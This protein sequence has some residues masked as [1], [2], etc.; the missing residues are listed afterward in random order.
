M[1][2]STIIYIIIAMAIVIIIFYYF[3]YIKSD[4]DNKKDIPY[5]LLYGREKTIVDLMKDISEK[6]GKYPAHKKKIK[7]K[8]KTISYS[9]YY[10]I[11]NIFAEKLL[12][13]VGP[14]PRVAILSFNRPEWVSAHMGTM[15]SG[16]VS[17]GIYPTASASNCTYITNHSHVD[18][19]VIEDAKQLAKFID[20][21][22]PTVKYIL[23]LDP[24]SIFDNE[25]IEKETQDNVIETIKKLNPNI[26]I[27]KYDTFMNQPLES[28]S[29]RTVIDMRK[30][31]LEDIATIIYTSGTTGDPKGVVLTHKNIIS[32]IKAV[33]NAI[34]SRSNINI[35]VQESYIS[36]LPLNHVAAQMMDIYVP[37]ASVGIVHF[38][39]KDAMKGSLNDTIKEVQ[40]TIF[41]GVPRIWEKIQSKIKEMEENP[42]RLIN[43]L[44]VNKMIIKKIGLD[45]AKIC[46][47]AAAPILQETR[48]FFND[49][50]I[51]LCD[52]YGMSETSGPISMGVPGCSHSVGVPVMDVK[53]DKK[54]GEISVKGDSVFKEYY[55]NKLATSDAFTSKGWFKTGDI[56]HIDRDGSM[57]VTGK[58][59]DIIITTGGENISPV[60]IEEE[61]MT[62]LN[63]VTKYIDYAVVIGD[64]RKFLS[65]LL[66]PAKNYHN[67]KDSHNLIKLALKSTNKKASNSTSTIK[68]Y[69][70]LNGEQFD[71]N[72]LI[73]PTLKI[74]RKIIEEKYKSK[75]DKLYENDQI[76]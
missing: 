26:N 33:L 37:L 14:H 17:V 9:E 47:T 70:I 44:F 50:G 8:W 27:I 67:D 20:V 12:Y 68:K 1:E 56:G 28:G 16:G 45:K 2:T 62:N 48:D 57:H 32:S 18:L 72:E 11:S 15:I 3:W 65:V 23:I 66:V 55:K 63:K 41:I 7:G 19:L 4:N 13:F 60:P 38:A 36:Y 49:L 46:I 30:P 21:K 52:V 74:R 76:N 51:E 54:T 5:K 43:R 10:Q 35:S 71:E 40:P 53:I 58:I 39:E 22:M 42:Q 25:L 73:T 75:I 59:K 34:Q 6:Y 61:L 29:T 31:Y 24:E 69:I 64:Q